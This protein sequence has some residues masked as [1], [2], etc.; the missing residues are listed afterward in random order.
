MKKGKRAYLKEIILEPFKAF[1]AE[2]YE[3]IE[4]ATSKDLIT[5]N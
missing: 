4:E 1:N 3:E 5:E 2:S